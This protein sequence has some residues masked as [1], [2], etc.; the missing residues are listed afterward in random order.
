MKKLMCAAVVT[1]LVVAPMAAQ[2]QAAEVMQKARAA[3]GG[4]RLEQIKA[5]AIEGPFAREMGNR[6]VQGKLALTLQL[7][8][9]MH[10]LEDTEMMGGVSL[11]RTAALNGETAWEDMQNRGGMGGGVQMV[12]RQGPPGGPEL[13]AEQ[14]EQARVRRLRTE[15]N[16]YLMAFLGASG[17]QPTYVAVAEAPEGKADVVEV[18]GEQGPGVRLF[19]DQATSMP[20][21]LQYQELRPRVNMMTGG[22]GGRRGPGA[23]SAS[24]ASGAS[25]ATSGDPHAPNP[26]EMRRRMENMPPPQPSNITLF[27]GD[28]KKVDGV[29]M[30]HRLTYA[31]DGKT[32]EEWTIEKIR[33]NPNIKADLFDK[34]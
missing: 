5:L 4:A 13:N 30:P 19:V 16:R 7:P 3:L 2:D 6:Q 29:M 34:K 8:G 1:A 10:R 9:K 18:K 17:L 27:L 11:E 24:G 26:E 28:Y 32:I 23:S 25:G 22:P 21:M 20:L 12:F 14:M 31:V 15:M 33:V